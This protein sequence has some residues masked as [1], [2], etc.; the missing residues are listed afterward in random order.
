[1][2]RYCFKTKS[3]DDCRPLHDMAEIGMPWWCTGQG[4]DFAT[5]VCYLPEW[6]SL[7]YYWDDAYDIST[8]R[9]EKITYT[10]RFPKPAWLQEN[11]SYEAI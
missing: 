8:E 4:E 3:R 10:D 6:L 9:R 2:I 11:N 5:V 1:M 7:Y